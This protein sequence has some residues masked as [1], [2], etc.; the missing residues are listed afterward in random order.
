VFRASE[1]YV[2]PPLLAREPGSVAWATW[3]FRL[4]GLLLLAL[5]LA[6]FVYVFLHFSNITGG[7]DP[8]LSNGLGPLSSP[9]PALTVL[10]AAG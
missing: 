7:E 6:L 9:L 10:P 2:R 5:T 3:R 1:Q 4:L 8:G